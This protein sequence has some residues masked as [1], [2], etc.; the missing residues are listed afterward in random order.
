MN[1]DFWFSG[2]GVILVIALLVLP[3]GMIAIG[4]CMIDELAYFRLNVL[5]CDRF[6]LACTLFHGPKGDSC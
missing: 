4:N 3:I 2:F 6:L 1:G 5:S